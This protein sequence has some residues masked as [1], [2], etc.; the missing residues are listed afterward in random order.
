MYLIDVNSQER[1]HEAIITFIKILPLLYAYFDVNILGSP[2]Q[3]HLWKGIDFLKNV[4]QN[5]DYNTLPAILKKKYKMYKKITPDLNSFWWYLIEIRENKLNNLTSGE[6]D[7]IAGRLKF[8]SD[9]FRISEESAKYLV[10]FEVK[11]SYFNSEAGSIKSFKDYSQKKDK[12]NEIQLKIDSMIKTGFNKVALLD[13][14][15]N[16]YSSSN[17]LRAYF[18][19]NNIASNSIEKIKKALEKRVPADSIAGHFVY[20]EGP[21]VGGDTTLKNSPSIKLIKPVYENNSIA[22]RNK[23]NKKIF[24]ILKEREEKLLQDKLRTE[25]PFALIDCRLCNKIHGLDECDIKD[26]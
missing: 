23:L 13:I 11:C 10:G 20:S 25:F 4:E 22:Y 8:H 5:N 3:Y 14:I 26:T 19:A 17:G 6:I 7:I 18:D 2:L 16:P 12:K 24:E 21:V 9:E 15:V 1:E